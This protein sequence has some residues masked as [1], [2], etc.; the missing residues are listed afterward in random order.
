[1]A[2]AYPVGGSVQTH[3]PKSDVTSPDLPR[4]TLHPQAL[5]LRSSE[6]ILPKRPRSRSSSAGGAVRLTED[7][8]L[9]L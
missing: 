9:T 7:L 2:S 8:F 4:P 5:S 1:M 6:L 3:G